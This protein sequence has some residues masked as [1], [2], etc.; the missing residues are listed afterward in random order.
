MAP[1]PLFDF[2]RHMTK[3][4]FDGIVAAHC[5]LPMERVNAEDPMLG[6]RLFLD[7]LNEQL[8]HAITPGRYLCVDESMEKWLGRINLMP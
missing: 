1:L 3:A 8:S 4:R 2:Q 6:A 7:A 5:L